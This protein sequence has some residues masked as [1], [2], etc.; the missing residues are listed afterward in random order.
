MVSPLDDWRLTANYSHLDMS[1]TPPAQDINRGEW[2]EGSTPRN[3]AGL[4][5]W[6]SLG[7]RFELD[8][9]FRYQSRIHDAAT[10]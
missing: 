6:L 9:Q 3:I 5:S 2:I 8:A 7:E 1:L 4:R 10:S